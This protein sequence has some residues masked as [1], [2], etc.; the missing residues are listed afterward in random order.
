MITKKSAKLLSE[1]YHNGDSSQT[2]NGH[3]SQDKFFNL[4]E[5]ARRRK[6]R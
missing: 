2:R 5:D 3:G 6:E 4:Y 1:R